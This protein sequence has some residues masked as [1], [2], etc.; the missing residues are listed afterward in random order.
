V[1]D[2]VVTIRTSGCIVHSSEEPLHGV[3]FVRC[4]DRVIEAGTIVESITICGQYT[5]Q[6]PSF[7]NKQVKPIE[8]V[9]ERILARRD[10]S[11]EVVL[12]GVRIRWDSGGRKTTGSEESGER[13]H[14]DVVM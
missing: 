5:I 4:E 8:P 12:R 2:P 1:I 10:L 7:V 3:V 9:K 14:A 6:F 13:T 11:L